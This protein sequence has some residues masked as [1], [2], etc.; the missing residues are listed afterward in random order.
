MPP[1][2]RLRPDNVLPINLDKSARD[3]GSA[4]GSSS[5]VSAFFGMATRGLIRRPNLARALLKAH[6]AGDPQLAKR[7]AAFHARLHDMVIVA[8]R[9]PEGD[10]DEA[11][12][13]SERL[14][15][16]EQRHLLGLL[17]RLI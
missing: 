16:H 3:C 5:R 2:D 9:G 12:S 6:A 11:P 7:T 10:R 8:L 1:D 15:T 13:E 17:R 4:G 14:L